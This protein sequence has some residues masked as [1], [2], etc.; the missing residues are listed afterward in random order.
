MEKKK[1]QEQK[2]MASRYLKGGGWESHVALGGA[3]GFGALGG[4]E[5]YIEVARWRVAV[6]GMRGLRGWV[7][8][9]GGIGGWLPEGRR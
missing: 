5:S 8:D 3:E 4:E 9:V 6:L 1:K 7:D 2:L